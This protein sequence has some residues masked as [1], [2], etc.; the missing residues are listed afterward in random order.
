VFSSYFQPGVVVQMKSDV[1][2][3]AALQLPFP[4][5]PKTGKPIPKAAAATM[6][7]TTASTALGDTTLGGTAA[8]ATSPAPTLSKRAAAQAAEAALW[9]SLPQIP[10]QTPGTTTNLTRGAASPAPGLSTSTAVGATTSTK[11]RWVCVHF[12]LLTSSLL[13]DVLRLPSSS[14]LHEVE[15]RIVA[16][17]GGSIRRLTMW[18]DDI[19][20]KNILRDFRLSL[21]E[22][23]A[24][25]DASPATVAAPNIPG[26]GGGGLSALGPASAAASFMSGS[27]AASSIAALGAP[28]VLSP[29]DHH[30]VIC[31]DYRAHDSDC[32][33]LLRSPRYATAGGAGTGLLETTMA[34]TVGG[35]AMTTVAQTVLGAPAPLSA[36][37]VP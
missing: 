2:L 26:G 35:A 29:E 9:A 14:T 24:L 7:S 10:K 20:P 22:V 19:Q 33:L 37:V 27:T 25:D 4:M 13:D 1:P 34:Q 6:S 28:F 5:P 16:H 17:H 11:E 18:K 15:A 32:P 21:R 23:W 36:S 31:Y 12:K 30:V 8:S 3:R